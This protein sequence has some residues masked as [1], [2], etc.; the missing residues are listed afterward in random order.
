V[1]WRSQTGTFEGEARS[2]NFN[3]AQ[4]MERAQNDTEEF[5]QGSA[6]ISVNVKKIA[7]A[8]MYVPATSLGER[9]LSDSLNTN[10]L[11]GACMMLTIHSRS[12][13]TQYQMTEKLDMEE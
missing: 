7:Q 3:L 1:K 10:L 9:Q 8:S 13:L 2:G 11:P 4:E 6:S 12:S 5:A